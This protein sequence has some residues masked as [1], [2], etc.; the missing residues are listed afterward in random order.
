MT[1][2]HFDRLTTVAYFYIVLR[3]AASRRFTG[4]VMSDF[5]A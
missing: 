5:D 2:E 4:G 3:F 1:V